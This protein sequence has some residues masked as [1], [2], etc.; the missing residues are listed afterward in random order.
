MTTKE[1]NNCVRHY[2]DSLYR[3]ALQFVPD[4]ASAED[5]VQ[6]S[7]VL[8]W[9]KIDKVEMEQ[10]KS[11][12]FTVTR[13]R[14]I[15]H[16][17]HEQVKMQYMSEMP[18]PEGQTTGYRQ[19]ELKDVLR[20]T[21]AKLPAIQKEILLLRDWEGFAYK[22][23]A[24]I[25]NVSEQQVMSYLFRARV[26]MRKHLEAEGYSLPSSDKKQRKEQL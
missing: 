22:E 21:L 4:T 13:N 8:L 11:F 23:I 25:A 16:I 10:A 19:M 7:F 9:E 5:T 26:A 12:L 2:S 18:E 20:K 17:R 14:M 24:E 6:E 15:D 1:Y 3:F